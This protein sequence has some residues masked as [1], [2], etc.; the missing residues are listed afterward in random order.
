MKEVNDALIMA[1]REVKEYVES[2][3]SKDLNYED[4]IK[5]RNYHIIKQKK[6]LYDTKTIQHFLS[7]SLART[8]NCFGDIENKDMMSRVVTIYMDIDD[9]NPKTLKK[10]YF[11]Q[12]GKVS[13]QSEIIK[14]VIDYC[15]KG[16]QKFI[17][18]Q[19][20]ELL[21]EHWNRI[22]MTSG[23]EMESNYLTTCGEFD[24][25]MLEYLLSDL[26]SLTGIENLKDKRKL[27]YLIIFVID[28]LI[29][30]ECLPKLLVIDSEFSVEEIG[31]NQ[32]NVHPDVKLGLKIKSFQSSNK[33]MGSSHLCCCTCSLFLDSFGLNFRGTNSQFETK[34]CLPSSLDFNDKTILKF[35]QK[36]NLLN[37][38]I[39]KEK[40]KN[41]ENIIKEKIGDNTYEIFNLVEF[42]IEYNERRDVDNNQIVSGITS[43]DTSHFME[44]ISTVS[45]ENLDKLQNLLQYLAENN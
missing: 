40:L 43:D 14:D 45:E 30:K 25:K 35:V 33:Y 28:F 3:K 19:I 31:K 7:D 16:K 34:W 18:E 24:E 6:F 41:I 37:V 8:T 42:E 5:L 12:K 32:I 27:H 44:H 38:K 22:K 39:S 11:S 29:L 13:N 9:S 23:L 36:L 15:Y 17:S 1:V 26:A 21:S 10:I 20:H 2:L 4:K